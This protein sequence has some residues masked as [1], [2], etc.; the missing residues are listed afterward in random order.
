MSL[1]GLNKDIYFISTSAVSIVTIF[2]VILWKSFNSQNDEKGINIDNLINDTTLTDNLSS[3]QSEQTSGSIEGS[4]EEDTSRN[5][6]N[7]RGEGTEYDADR[8]RGEEFLN[9]INLC[10]FDNSRKIFAKNDGL[11]QLLG[12]ILDKNGNCDNRKYYLLEYNMCK[13]GVSDDVREA[14]RRELRLPQ[15]EEYIKF[16][17]IVSIAKRNPGHFNWNLTRLNTMP[18]TAQI[19]RLIKYLNAAIDLGNIAIVNDCKTQLKNYITSKQCAL[20]KDAVEAIVTE[21]KLDQEIENEDELHKFVSYLKENACGV[22]CRD[23]GLSQPEEYI[24]FESI[25][26]IAKRNPGLFN[27]NLTRLKTMPVTDRI[28]RL[29]TCLNTAIDSGDIVIVNDCRTRLK[30]YITSKEC[31]LREGAGEIIVIE[32]KLDKEIESEDELHQFVSDLIK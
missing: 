19:K 5:I 1:F 28:K 15:L 12:E 25:I 7:S 26:N 10:L 30:N 16:E 11:L 23:L 21:L 32:L 2:T 22:I 31:A 13:A 3:T 17:A 24:K 29:V 27:W 6:E 14:I 20:M 9:N 18:V 4:T 8:Q